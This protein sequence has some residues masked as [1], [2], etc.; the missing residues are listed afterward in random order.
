MTGFS[1]FIKRKWGKK[2]CFFQ[3][4]ATNSPGTEFCMTDK[5][6]SIDNFNMLEACAFVNNL[7]LTLLLFIIMQ[8]SVGQ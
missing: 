1:F 6:M 7:N 2:V 8:V 4:N 3:G 5:P